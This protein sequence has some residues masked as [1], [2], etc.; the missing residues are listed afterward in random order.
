M[1]RRICTALVVTVAMLALVTVSYGQGGASG[2]I[3]GTVTDNTGAIVSNATVQITNVATGVTQ[4]TSTGGGGDYTVPNLNPGV[5]RVTVQ[6]KGFG[7]EV[8]DNITVAVAQ[9]ARVNVS[10]KPGNV[11]ETV[12][13]NSGAVALDT[14]NAAITQL[15]SQRQVDQLPLNGRNFLN[16]LFIGAG[17]VQTVGEQGQM[18]QG[19]GNAISINGGRPE[20]NNYTLDGM[21]N[22]DTALNTP[23]VILSQDAIQEFKVQSETYSAE[24]GFSANQVN[25][26]S[27]SG[28]NQLHGSV[29]EFNRNDAFDANTHFQPVKPTLRQNQF[30]FVAGGPVYI[31]KFYDGRNKTFWLANYEGW[32]IKTGSNGFYHV[33]SAAELNGDFSAT[34]FPAFGTPEC[35]TALST[36]NPCVP[37]DPNT[38]LPFP[39]NIVPADRFSRVANV[40]LGAKLFPAPNCFTSDCLGNY[41]LVTA[42]PT[43]TDQQTYRLDQALGRFGGVFFRYT[44]GKYT[45]QNV[46]TLSLPAGLNI[47]NEDSTSWEIA[48][49]ITLGR[50]IVNSFR[51]GSLSAKEIQGS[52]PASLADVSA[53]GVTGVFTNLP[54]YARGYPT[55]GFQNLDTGGSPGNNP[56]TSDI[57]MWEYADSV[58]MARGKHTIGFGFDFRT[59]IQK[60][61]LSGNFLGGY[62][63]NNNNILQNSPGCTTPSGKCGTGNAVADFLLGYYNSANTFQPEP[64]STPG[65][66]G[67]E[68][69]FHF[70]YLAPYVEDDWKVTE[71]LTL[72]LGLRWDY[73]SVPVES[74]D[75][76]FWIDA[77]NTDGGLC[78]ARQALLTDG[79]APEGNGFYRYCGR[80]NPRD[81][82]KLPFAPR[83]GFAYRPP[84]G[85][86]K[87]VIRGGYG[88]YFDS[89]ETREIDDSGDLYPFVSRTQESPNI[90]PNAPKSTNN[91]FPATSALHPVSVAT[92]GGQFIA[93]I[94]SERPINPYVQQWSLSVQRELARNFTLEVNY[95][96]NK[97]THLLDRVNINQPNPV[98]NPALCQAD[99]TAGDCPIADRRPYKNFTAFA[100][101]D[102]RWDGYSNYN[103]GNV[104]LERRTSDMA[105]VGAY[106]WAK[107]M[108]DKSAAAGIGSAGG[109]FAGHLDDHN[110][111][112]DYA[113]SD[114]DVNQRFVA[115]YVYNLPFGRGRKY[116]ANINRAADAAIG[117]WEVTGIA[118]FQKGF[119][120]SI[121]ATDTF[122]LLTAYS[123]RANL[124]GDPNKGFH[125]DINHWFNT[126]AFAQPLAGEYGN[127]GRNILRG[128]GINNWDMGVGKEFS[129]L[130]RLHFQFRVESFNTFNHTQWGVDPGA[131]GVGPGANAVDN[132]IADQPPNTNTNFGR[133]TSA[134]PGRILQLGGKLTF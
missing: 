128:P 66:P 31:P 14:D 90:D 57:P 26:V 88:V 53:L 16:L 86:G 13:I 1:L 20:S 27:K 28:T 97:A 101:L 115:S 51:V 114:F 43:T 85:A 7:N 39:G 119:P 15:V 104:K 18:R 93:V 80:R 74:H 130:E 58:T 32:R 19:E 73:R 60:R 67:N 61:N 108:D 64:F 41:H 59:W 75:K 49:N 95:V 134:R 109:G 62:S 44:K 30:G 35:D 25:I 116:L 82:S 12:Q 24:Y 96:G 98:A 21:A 72:N 105:F 6:L 11:S 113:R 103:A 92:E 83:L 117:G 2:T 47:F 87:T 110:P 40:S 63:Y 133:I 55:I 112:L 69:D 131:P 94:I 23:A 76:M 46:G 129:I 10:L 132:N 91:L 50:S 100:T 65:I 4:K 52:T 79:V 125:K 77:A 29:F 118:T 45:L 121:N 34:G 9:Q 78:Y 5:Y 48:H 102:S 56:S 126:A 22:T 36:G 122:G 38:G 42:L 71:N 37:I 120:Y 81:G 124:V 3:L 89:S 123:Q 111:Q 84:F 70:K 8:V 68:N 33:P 17:A 99:P 54:A 106:T 127:S 107:S